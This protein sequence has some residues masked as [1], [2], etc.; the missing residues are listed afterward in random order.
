M[1]K[2]SMEKKKHAS[3]LIKLMGLL[4]TAKQKIQIQ[5][6]NNVDPEAYKTNNT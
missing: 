6:G 3:A 2:E 1:E 5:L 4:T